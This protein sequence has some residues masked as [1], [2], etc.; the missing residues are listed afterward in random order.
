MG[1]R[2]GW[3]GTGYLGWQGERRYNMRLLA[4]FPYLILLVVIVVM[5]LVGIAVVED[6]MRG[7]LVY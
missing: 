3:I 4:T 6:V 2:T 7:I 1:N 5:V